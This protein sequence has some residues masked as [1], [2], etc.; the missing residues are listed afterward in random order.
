MAAVAA[1][2]RSA[3]FGNPDEPPEGAVNTKGNPSSTSDPGPNNPALSNQ[4]PTAFSPPATN[5]GSLP[6]FWASFNN[7]PRRIQ[8]GGWARQVTQFDFQVSEQIAGVNMRLTRGGIREL[9]WHQAAEWAYVTYG[10]CRVTTIDQF[11]RANVEDVHEGGLWYF[12][13]GMPHSLQGIGED[14]CEFILCFDDGK[15]TEFITL[16]VTDW[17]A[18]TPPEDLALNFG[19]AAETFSKIPLHDLYIFQGELP[20]PIEADQQQAQGD[21]GPSPLP[22]TFQLSEVAP[23]RQTKGGSVR[24]ADSSNFKA[25]K[26]IAASQV[27]IHP[28]GMREMHWHPNADEWLYI[29]AGEGRATVFNTGPNVSSQNFR[30]GDIGYVKRNYGHYLRNTGNTDLVYLEVFR[31]SYFADI[32]LSD[33]LTHTPPALVAQHFNIDP[34]VIAQFPRNKPV[35]VPV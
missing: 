33:W 32:S 1:T 24:V 21:A 5:V 13:A 3:S 26:T 12:P 9:H 11:G 34:K 19:V 7:A 29:I 18:H 6:M 35:I 22:S 23:T 27:T 10:T 30:A 8:N 15:A 14:G 31:S 25:S 20:G 28:G 2:A 4:F 17:V 16:L